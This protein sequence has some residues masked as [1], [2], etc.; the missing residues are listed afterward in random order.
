MNAPP[1]AIMVGV[2]GS[3]DSDRAVE[4]AAAAA[5]QRQATLHLV[6]AVPPPAFAVPYTAADE[7]AHQEFAPPGRCNLPLRP[8]RVLISISRPSVLAGAPAQR[9][10]H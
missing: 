10:D 3:A 5:S 9:R 6:Y 2:D 8:S 1:G 4:W 7:Q